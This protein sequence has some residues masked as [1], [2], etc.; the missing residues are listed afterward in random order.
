M[1]RLSSTDPETFSVPPK[2]TG[3]RTLHA[4]TK[5]FSKPIQDRVEA[6]A[7]RLT[8]D[9]AKNKAR[10]ESLLA[11]QKDGDIRRGQLVF[12]STKAA[13]ASCHNLYRK[14]GEKSW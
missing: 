9:A 6:L 4:A 11:N 14:D 2:S 10:L 12:N 5:H 13:C 1:F 3:E 7:A 8:P